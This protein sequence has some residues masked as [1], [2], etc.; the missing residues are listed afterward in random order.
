MTQYVLENESLGAKVNCV[1]QR[2]KS[3]CK[4][5]ERMRQCGCDRSTKTFFN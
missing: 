4:A 2:N 3:N 1:L 5:S